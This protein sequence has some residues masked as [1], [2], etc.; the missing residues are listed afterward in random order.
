M[1]NQS[2]VSIM[3]VYGCRIVKYSLMMIL[4]IDATGCAATFQSLEDNFDQM[5]KM[6]RTPGEQS[7]ALPDDVWRNN[8]CDH[9]SR[10]WIAMETFEVVPRRLSAGE[11]FN[12]RMTYA[13][14]SNKRADEIRGKL[15]TRIYYQG[16]AIVN[17]VKRGYSLKPGRWQVDTFV[18]IPEYA[19][20]GVYSVEVEF[21]SKLLKVKKSE[22]FVVVSH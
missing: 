16:K 21:R 20:Q 13:L 11:D 12:L 4:L 22:S 6:Q 3:A 15:Y 2:V 1:D 5:R 10:P 8:D 9:V 17:D 14:C 7:L 19:K 18:T